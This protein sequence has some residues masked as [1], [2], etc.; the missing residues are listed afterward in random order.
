[1]ITVKKPYE[2]DTRFSDV[3]QELEKRKS[4]IKTICFKVCS[5]CGETKLI[6]KFSTD[7]RNTDGRHGVCKV[8]RSKESLEY[9]YQNRDRI[10]I[11]NKEYQKTNKKDR[12]L[13]FKDYQ[14]EHKELKEEDS[15]KSIFLV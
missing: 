7:K 14:R 3:E 5:K 6:F 13:Y 8:C 10:L 2:F 1:M 15:F 9:Y 4:R 12:S 11:Q